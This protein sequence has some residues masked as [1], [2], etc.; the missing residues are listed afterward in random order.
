VNKEHRK[1]GNIIL[2][3]QKQKGKYSKQNCC[4]RAKLLQRAV[5][6]YP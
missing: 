2:L 5:A 4:P 3:G 1:Y 6:L